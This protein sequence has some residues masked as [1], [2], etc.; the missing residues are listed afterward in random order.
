MH[1]PCYV[2][3]QL[4]THLLPTRLQLLVLWHIDLKE[5]GRLTQSGHLVLHRLNVLVGLSRCDGAQCE[6]VEWFNALLHTSLNC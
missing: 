2:Y 1:L 4:V 5:A 3:L 6:L